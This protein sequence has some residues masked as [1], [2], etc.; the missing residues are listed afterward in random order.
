MVGSCRESV[1]LTA[2]LSMAGLRRNLLATFNEKVG[3]A[4]ATALPSS[5]VVSRLGGGELRPV[6][7]KGEEA[8]LNMGRFLAGD[9]ASEV[10]VKATLT[11]EDDLWRSMGGDSPADLVVRLVETIDEGMGSREDPLLVPLEEVEADAGVLNSTSKGVG[12]IAEAWMGGDALIV[13]SLPESGFL[14]LPSWVPTGGRP[15]R[16]WPIASASMLNTG[17]GLAASSPD[18]SLAVSSSKI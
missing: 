2:V 3:E 14:R 6:L 5:G 9:V 16:G 11:M 18:P 10:S 7:P 17:T 12:G 13:S 4:A 8:S 1:V 15:F